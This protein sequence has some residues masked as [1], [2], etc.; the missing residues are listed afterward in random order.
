MPSRFWV[1]VSIALVSACRAASPPQTEPAK[2]VALAQPAPPVY[3]EPFHRLVFQNRYARVLDVVIPPGVTT[4]FHIHAARTAGVVV[5][6]G[7]NW[8]Q[9]LGAPPGAVAPGYAVGDLIENWTAALPYTH[10][11]ANVD[12]V[13][14]HY[15]TGEWLASP[16][17]DAPVPPETPSRHL[18]RE[19]A[20]A[21]FYRVQLAPGVSTEAH[22]HAAPGLTV[23]L[24]AGVVEDMGPAPAGTGGQ[25]AEAWRWRD[26]DCRHVLRNAG[27]NPVQI[28]EIDWR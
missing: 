9:I 15:I 16:G 18:V 23:Q 12:T 24:T 17:I 1:I 25:G 28:M 11:V 27:P 5:E 26:A 4:G 3:E 21:R 20:V 2:A 14:I 8:T 10:R 6:G 22:T 13:P 19:G 7:R